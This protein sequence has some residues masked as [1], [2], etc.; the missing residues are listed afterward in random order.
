MAKK[1]AK[2]VVDKDFKIAEIDK[3]VYG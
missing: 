1:Y 3:R 2:M